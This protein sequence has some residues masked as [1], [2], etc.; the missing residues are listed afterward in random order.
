M[1]NSFVIAF[2]AVVPMFILV[3]IGML[4]RKSGLI[5]KDENRKFN[6]IAFKVFF[7]ALMFKDRKSVV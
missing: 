5:T 7:S 1:L 6:K 3:G 2:E 4:V